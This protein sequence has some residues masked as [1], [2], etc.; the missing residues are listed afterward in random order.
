MKVILLILDSVGIGEAPD[1]ADFGDI[2][3]NTL[4]HTAAAV[5]GLRLPVLTR[6]GLGK[7]PSLLPSGIAIA[8]VPPFDEPIA[9]FG[10][11]REISIGKDT[12]TGHWEMAGL[13]L[14]HGFRLFPADHPSFPPELTRRIEETTGRKIIGNTAANGMAII[15][16]LGEQQIND[17][18]WIVYTSADSVLQIAAHEETIPLEE[19]YRAC[20]TARKLCNE[21]HVGRV[22]ARPF[23]GKPGA[24]TRTDNRRDFSFPLPEA[25][26]LDRL[27]ASGTN[28]YAIGKIEDIFNHRGITHSYHTGSNIESQ[29]ALSRLAKEDVEGL[30]F[31]NLIDF[32]QL[33]G[34]RR[35]PAGYGRALEQ[36]DIFLADLLPFLRNGD[37]L[38]ISADHGNDPTFTGTDHTRE[39]VPLLH[40]QPGKAGTSIGL[41]HGF[42][43]VAQTLASLFEIPPMPRGISFA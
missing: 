37:S 6:M 28:V 36:T 40:Y 33:H 41:R 31:A 24:F 23:I 10:A 2:G 20:E 16:E 8:G 25:T 32:D 29:A 27:T 14:E 17:G 13:L 21:Y 35:D 38:I 34:H 18:S 26:I 7:I 19:L 43:D 1:A 4:A 39:Y 30:I 15:A 22:I 11:M 42:F 9:D 3:A 5:G 12:I